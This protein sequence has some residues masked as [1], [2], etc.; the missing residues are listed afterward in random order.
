MRTA[1]L[2][3]LV[4]LAFG[5]LVAG[6]RLSAQVVNGSF[7]TGDLAGWTTADL[8]DPHV[9]LQVTEGGMTDGMLSLESN[10]TD[11]EF[12]L[13]TGF[14]GAGPGVISLAQ[15]VAIPSSSGQLLFDFSTEWNL[16][17]FAESTIDRTF[18]VIV[19]EA[20]GVN[21]LQAVEVLRVPFA[22]VGSLLDVTAALNLKEHAGDTVNVKLQ[23]NVPEDFTGPAFFDLDDL[24]LAGKKVASADATSLK[25]KL[26][27]LQ[28]NSKDTLKLTLKVPVGVDFDPDG[29]E[30]SVTVGDLVTDFVLDA[31]GHGEVE[32]GT[33]KVVADPANPELRKVIMSLKAG[34]F[35]GDL[36]SFGVEDVDTPKGGVTALVP[37]SVDMD[38]IT[39]SEEIL[40][41]YKAKEGGTGTASGKAWP[42]SLPGKLDVKLDFA[43]PDSDKITLKTSA[44]TLPAFEPEGEDVTIDIG[45]Y[46][47]VMTLDAAGHAEEDGD[48][49]VLKR[50]AKNPSRQ[51]LTFKCS[52]RDVQSAMEADGLVDADVASPGDEL[53]VPVTIQVGGRITRLMVPMTYTATAGV[54]GHAVGKL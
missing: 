8:E 41:V 15:D 3:R 23:W 38:E 20:G 32:G 42:E 53:I 30:V 50:D 39:T 43:T 21:E 40:V 29:A 48:S 46:Q 6:D 52:G 47:R 9:D 11:G 54:S 4:A 36:E 17:E 16:V 18:S 24:R 27:L 44:F 25:V 31:Q 51:V 10:P 13:V 26:N 37:V 35:L 19:S 2:A 1:A 45:S 49:L 12:S 22:T 7:E 28:E 5:V 33:L 14:D 34:D